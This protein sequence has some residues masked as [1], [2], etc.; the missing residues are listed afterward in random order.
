MCKSEESGLFLGYP[1]TANTTGCKCPFPPSS[2][3]GPFPGTGVP[4]TTWSFHTQSALLCV[5]LPTRAWVPS[6]RLCRCMCK[7]DIL[8]LLF[9]HLLQPPGIASPELCD[10]MVL[11]AEKGKLGQRGVGCGVRDS[12]VEWGGP[13]THSPFNQGISSLLFKLFP[14]GKFFYLFLHKRYMNQKQN[15]RK[16]FSG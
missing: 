1:V 11:S 16:G 12:Q 14:Q 2:P 9:F 10:L 6:H 3:R 15:M 13:L 5:L 8:S 4:G 7:T